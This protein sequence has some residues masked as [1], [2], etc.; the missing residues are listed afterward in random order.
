M[1]EYRLM[2]TYIPSKAYDMH[3]LIENKSQGFM[4]RKFYPLGTPKNC[5]LNLGRDRRHNTHQAIT[6]RTTSITFRIRSITRIWSM[7]AE[8]EH[9]AATT[10]LRTSIRRRTG[11]NNNNIHIK[12]RSTR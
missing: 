4:F 9:H 11:N 2:T 6:I 1:V 12:I 10:M 3:T 7:Q 5:C 8:D